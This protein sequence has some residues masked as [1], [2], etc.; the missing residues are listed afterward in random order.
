V[1]ARLE[2]TVA[3]E[4]WP[5]AALEYVVEEIQPAVGMQPCLLV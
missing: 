4:I 3:E 5:L 1:E 2:L